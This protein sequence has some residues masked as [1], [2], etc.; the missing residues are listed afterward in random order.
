MQEGK[1][2]TPAEGIVGSAARA[3]VRPIH[4]PLED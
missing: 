3:A 1:R 4:G 2:V